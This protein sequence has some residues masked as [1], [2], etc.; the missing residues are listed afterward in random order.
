MFRRRRQ[1]TE[2]DAAPPPP[3][4]PLLWPWLLLLLALVNGAR[5]GTV[6]SQTPSAETEL[7]RGAQV[8]IVVAR[9]PSTVA[10]PNVVGLSA[11][12]ALVRLQ[13]A[14]LKGRNVLI[15]SVQPKGRVI[16]Q[17]PAGGSQAKKGSTVAL[18]ISK[19]SK[20]VTVPPVVGLTEAAATATL[21][22]LGFR[23]SVSR[24]SSPKPK[25]TVVSQEPAAGTRA[26]KGSIV[27]LNVSTGP[28]T[29]TGPA[30]T[31]VVVPK[32]VGL[33]QGA[34]FTRIERVGLRPNSFPVASSRPTGTVASQAPPGGT[35][36]TP[37][38]SVRVDV[39]QGTGKAPLRSV[40]D[41]VGQTEKEARRTL[42]AAGFTV[43]SA[44]QPITKASENGIVVRQKPVAGERAPVASQVVIY[45]GRLPVPSD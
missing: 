24:I 21:S 33:S 45:V 26:Q 14:G 20:P 1:V 41:T 37:R 10:V 40:P 15:Q 30:A 31:G 17:A 19:G 29:T 5:L 6:L 36:A 13:A 9:G 32:V 3:R 25:G 35:R 8:T 44:D 22:R 7:D 28:S 34:A 12:Q 27:G 43:Q 42:V 16:R 11:A 4:R 38:S 39:S 2:Y 23:L 18:T